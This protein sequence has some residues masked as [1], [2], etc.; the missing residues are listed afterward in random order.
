MMARTMAEKIW[1]DHAIGND[2]LFIDLHLVH[3]VSSPQA[4]EGLRQAGR[5]VRRVDRT[6]AT[7]DH[8]VPTWEVPMPKASAPNAPCVDVWES[9]HTIVMPGWVMP[10]C[11]P[12]TWTMPCSASPIG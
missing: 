3:E 2:L 8:N 5:V 9:P 10:S 4:F 6:L 1:D 11:G 7:A 12:M